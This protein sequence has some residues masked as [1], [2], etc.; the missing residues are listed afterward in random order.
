MKRLAVFFKRHTMTGC[1]VLAVLTLLSVVAAVGIGPVLIPFR[2]VWRIIIHNLTG[3]GELSD[4][5][6]NTHNI[7][8]FLRTPRVLLGALSGV[9]LT[10]SGISMQAFTKNPLASP[11]VLGISSGAYFGAVVAMATNLLSF[12]GHFAVSVGAFTGSLLAILGVYFLA[13]TGTDVAPIRLV[14]VGLSTSAIF[15]AFGNL[16]VYM[17]PDVTKVRN[18]SFWML[19]S[20]ASAE[21]EDLIPLVIALPPV[22]FM[23]LALSRSMNAMM[24][25][26]SSAVT[27]G[28][29]VSR[30]RK[31]IIFAS[32]VLTGTAV[33]VAGCIGFIGLIIPHIVRSVVGADHRR[34]IP[35]SVFTGAMFLIWADVIAR[36]IN[37]PSE[38]PIGIITAII[39]APVFL[40]MVRMRRYSFGSES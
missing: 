16:I 7:V 17:S 35:L 19:G 39:G 21:W 40:W 34:V 2:T 5:R 13:K 36:M 3:M 15:N 1:G 9:S 38:T 22:L 27:L 18:A 30:D 24:M 28:I 8:W 32:A 11:Y 10:V 23:L 25:G 31:M 4:I 29:E 14:L 20:L 6:E 33:A 26:E 12:F 37:A